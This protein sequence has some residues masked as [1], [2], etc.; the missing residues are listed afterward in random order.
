LAS[1]YD[2]DVEREMP[3]TR[4]AGAL[5]WSLLLAFVLGGCRGGTSFR[6]PMHMHGHPPAIDLE[7]ERKAVYETV[8][9][10]YLDETVERLVID[11]NTTPNWSA[12]DLNPPARLRADTK[13]DY[14]RL[15]VGSLPADLDVGVPIV[16]FDKAD[17]EALQ[18]AVR[19]SGFMLDTKWSAFHHRFPNSAGWMDLSGVG[20]SADGRQALVHVWSGSASLA[21][22][23]FFFLLEKR[24]GRWVIVEKTMTVIS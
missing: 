4:R 11:P 2:V 23:G 3:M 12:T 24:A 7:A 8:L 15:P 22:A 14:R 21:G 6:R 16:W 13:A 18:P 5:A 17:W 10:E 19:P 1:G 20:L 9:R